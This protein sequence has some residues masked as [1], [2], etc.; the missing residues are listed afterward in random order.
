MALKNTYC[1]KV[2]DLIERIHPPEVI[3]MERR[4]EQIDDA[5]CDQIMQIIVEPELKEAFKEPKVGEFFREMVKH[6][7]VLGVTDQA[8]RE[9][10][11]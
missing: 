6:W 5:Y 7:Y 4:L 8:E 2:D 1:E 3:S 11:G 9:K 10:N